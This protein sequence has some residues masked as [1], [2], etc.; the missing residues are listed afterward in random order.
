V[1]G[2]AVGSLDQID[3]NAIESITLLK[4]AASTAIYGNRASAG[5]VLV[6]T[7]RATEKGLQV[8]Y[9][10]FVTQQQATSLPNRVSA[11]DHMLLSNEAEKNR[12]GNP[13]ATVFP[14]TLIDRYRTT[15]PNNLDVI[16][17][18]LQEKID[19]LFPKERYEVSITGK[20]VV[21]QKGT[22]YLLDNLLQ[23]LLLSIFITA[24]LIAFMFRSIKM[25]I[26]AL[27][28]NLLP[29]LMTAGIMGYFNIPLKPSTILVFGIAFGLSVDDTIRFL[30]E[31]RQSLTRNNWKIK[32]SVF[33]TINESGLSMF[34]TSVVLFS[35]FSVFMLSSFG[36]TIALGG[37]V[38]ITLLFGMLS[39]LV[40]LPS[41]VLTLN[42]TLANQQEF[43]EPTINILSD[44]EVGEI[45][46]IESN[47]FEEEDIEEEN[48][49]E[50]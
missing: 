11:I 17:S 43:L 14:L 41:L 50:K 47:E 1:D 15:A 36:G 26:V 31:Y 7:K 19:E 4:D 18:K 45:D 40:L 28:P 21:F 48:S 16:E 3:P 44:E 9:N 24:L 22:K 33:A 37:L 6:K 23:S 34:Y 25:I 49:N 13:A 42:K 46:K 35:G 32:K 38:S 20:A 10:A 27:V 39:N 29:L 8:N 12:T 30:A 5:V 2:L